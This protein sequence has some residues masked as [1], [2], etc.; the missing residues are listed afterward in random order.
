MRALTPPMLARESSQRRSAARL[1]HSRA[2]QFALGKRSL[3]LL[4]LPPSGTPLAS[5]AALAV[6]RKAQPTRQRSALF[7][8]PPSS[9]LL[10]ARVLHFMAVGPRPQ[11]QVGQ[12]RALARGKAEGLVA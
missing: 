9:R 5:K 6:A 7:I 3:M 12:L 4:S 2:L 8:V 1:D 10:D 11:P